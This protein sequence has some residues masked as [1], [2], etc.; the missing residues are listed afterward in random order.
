MIYIPYVSLLIAWTLIMVPRQIVSTEMK[1]LGGGYNNNEPRTQQAQLEGRGKR[2]LGAHLNGF[3][4]FAP[5]AAGV[6]ACA[7]T[8][9]NL[10]ITASLCAAFVVLRGIYIFA[11]LNDKA[12]LRSAAWGLGYACTGT[13]LVLPIIRA[14]SLA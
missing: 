10:T 6:L 9:A 8:G 1:K 13:L 14:A 4:A 3:E 5:F 2:A 7:Q 12:G 11:Y